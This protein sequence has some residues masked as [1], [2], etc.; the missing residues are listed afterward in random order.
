MSGPLKDVRVVVLAGLGPGPFTSML[1]ADLG[2]DVVRIVRPP[3]RHARALDQTAGFN[4]RQNVVNRGT[5]ATAVDLKTSEGVSMVTELAAEA[6]VF[7]EGF[8]PGVA[9]RLGL[10]PMEVQCTNPRIVY[11]RLTGFG[12]TSEFAAAAGHDINYV[13]ESGALHAMGAPGIRPKPPLNI[14]GDYAGG[15][16]LAAY[17]IVAAVLNARSNGQGQVVDSG[18]VDGVALLTSKLQGLR[19]AGLLGDEP[20][21]NFIDSGAPFYDTYQCADG[22]YIAVGALEADFYR[23]FI[24][25]LGVDT[26]S[27]PDQNDQT[28]WPELRGRIADTIKLRSM[29]EWTG[30]FDALD[31]CVSPVLTYGEA[32]LR[33][34]QRSVYSEIDGALHPAP[35]PRFSGTPARVPSAPSTELVPMEEIL[36]GWRG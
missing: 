32:A 15:G 21:T 5:R 8:R 3:H 36:R 1:L 7:I 16:T 13:A 31:A 26:S 29:V 28:R 24:D 33:H 12:Q 20:G 18:M 27:W 23:H 19:A 2:A 6:D 11:A 9:E 14:L 17:G 30:I 10:G 4:E 25:G 34:R 22:R 35:A